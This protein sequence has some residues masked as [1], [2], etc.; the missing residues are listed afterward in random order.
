M[1]G[2][3]PPDRNLSGGGIIPLNRRYVIL[4]ATPLLVI[5]V[6]WISCAFMSSGV[7]DKRHLRHT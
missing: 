3:P 6:P 1:P 4:L 5:A 7:R 2:I